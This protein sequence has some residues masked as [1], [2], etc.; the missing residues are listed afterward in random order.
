MIVKLQNKSGQL[1]FIYWFK[2]FKKTD[3]SY[4]CYWLPNWI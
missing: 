4:S 3:A 1:N 2:A